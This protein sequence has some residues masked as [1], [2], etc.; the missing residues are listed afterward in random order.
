LTDAIFDQ[1][2]IVNAAAATDPTILRVS[3]DAKATV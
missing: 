1:L 2:A 3:S